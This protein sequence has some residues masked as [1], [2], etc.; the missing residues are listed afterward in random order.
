LEKNMVARSNAVDSIASTVL[1]AAA[2]A[3]GILGPHAFGVAAT[4]T[5]T[6]SAVIVEPISISTTANLSFGQIDASTT[7]TVTVDTSGA[8]HANGVRL[9][10][11]TPAAAT[12]S[13][14]GG[15][16][17][18]YTIGYSGTST[19]LTNGSD[20]LQ[21]NIVSDLGGAA[22]AS[23]APVANGTL[24]A[25][26]TVLRIGGTLGVTAGTRPGTYTGAI[27]AAVQYQ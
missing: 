18:A 19:T 9:A 1:H 12:F 25:G 11:G 26:P 2:V 7:G 14:S 8:R 21:L 13:I 17:L 20:T 23:G 22:T 6:A 5:A 4:A 24:G 3:A 15:A 10:G 27:A 16:G